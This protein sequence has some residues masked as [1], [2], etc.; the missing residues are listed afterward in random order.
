MKKIYFSITRYGRFYKVY[1][2]YGYITDEDLVMYPDTAY[3]K[4]LEDCIRYC[5]PIIGK[6]NQFKGSFSEL[7]EVEFEAKPNSYD[8]RLCETSYDIWFKVV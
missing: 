7:K 1:K 2:G 4:V 6:Y 8:T 3:T 5:H